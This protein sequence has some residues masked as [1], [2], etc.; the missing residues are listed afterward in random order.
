MILGNKTILLILS[1]LAI[2]IIDTIGAIASRKLN[3]KYTILAVFSFAVYILIGFY[4]SKFWDINTAIT[5]AL[6]VGTY[7]ATIGLWLSIKL[8]ANMGI[9]EEQL[10]RVIGIHSIIVML[11]TALIFSTIGYALTQI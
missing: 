11:I 4:G 5:I 7:D 9:T 6:L 3:F 1:V 2:T 8:K 10:K